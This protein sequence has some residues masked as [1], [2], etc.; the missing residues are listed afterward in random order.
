MKIKALLPTIALTTL[1]GCVNFEALE[2]DLHQLTGKDKSAAFDA[3]G[4][5]DNQY[6]IDDKTVFTWSSSETRSAT[7]PQTTTNASLVNGQ[8]VWTKSTSSTT[9]TGVLHC[10]VK[11]ITDSTGVIEENNI[12][13]NNGCKKYAYRLKTYLSPQ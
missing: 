6:T 7:I 12:T 1:V 13:G 3:L 5:P 11:I 8:A 9:T 10:T 2:M 4:Y